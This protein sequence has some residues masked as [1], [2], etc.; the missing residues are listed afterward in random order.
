MLEQL[1][2]YGWCGM[3]S[4]LSNWSVI[5]IYL[6]FFEVKLMN[7]VTCPFPVSG[8][9][10]LP[11]LWSKVPSLGHG[12]PFSGPKSFLGILLLWF[13]VV[14]WGYPSLWF[15][16]LSGGIPLPLQHPRQNYTIT[17]LEYPSPGHD[18][19]RSPLQQPRLGHFPR[20]D[21]YYYLGTSL[22]VLY[23]EF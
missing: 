23:I 18:R 6:M 16:V 12:T 4:Y 5:V 22:V 3:H 1:V 2:I 19:V 14:S 11:S 20:K 9:M 17:K 7:L 8:H 13:Q 10:S 21:T 15:Q